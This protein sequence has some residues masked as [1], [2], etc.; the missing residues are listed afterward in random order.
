MLTRAV[1]EGLTGSE[2]FIPKI[3]HSHGGQAGTG[4]WQKISVPLVAS[5]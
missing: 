2:G 4:C 3:T 1:I 5:L